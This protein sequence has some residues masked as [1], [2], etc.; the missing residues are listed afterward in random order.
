M[1][2]LG[3]ETSCDECSASLVDEN[4][5][6]ITNI[7]SSQVKLH[8]KYGGI[9]PEIAARAHVETVIPVISSA[10]CDG[11][12]PD[13]VSV[14]AGPGLVGSLLVGVSAAK[15]LAWGFGIPLVAVNHVEAH[16]ISPVCEGNLPDFPYL[17][18]VI[19]GG[20]TELL[21]FHSVD[22]IE[23]IGQ[24]VDDAAGEAY[25]K[26][27]KFLGLGYPGGPI[28][29]KL[30]EQGDSAAIDFPRA[31]MSSLD[32]N[33]S[34]SGLKT[35]VIRYVERSKMEGD[36]PRVEDIVSSF[37]AAAL[38]VVVSKTV[39]AALKTGVRAVVAGGGVACNRTLRRML[40][41]QCERNGIEMI[42][43]S[44]QYCT[45]NGA[46]VAALGLMR[47]EKGYRSGLDLDV[48]PS[49]RVGK[50]IE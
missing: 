39:R 45:D 18:L 50:K 46:M 42:V 9:V 29:D 7:V 2:V 36:M 33:F 21:F 8:E 47:Y 17:A 23:I 5:R 27:A 24:T 10:L 20:H 41:S 32:Y 38:E 19:S 28:I 37:Q 40:L 30:S 34:F 1:L 25:D 6:V 48:Y 11:Y 35:A 15:A 4:A 44:P 31:M 49:L 22:E 16:A 13:L 3:I 12:M 26:V 14:T 43:S